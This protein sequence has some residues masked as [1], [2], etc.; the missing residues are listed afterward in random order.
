MIALAVCC[1][2]LSRSLALVSILIL[3]HESKPEPHT[4]SLHCT[5]D[6]NKANK[7]MTMDSKR[8]ATKLAGGGRTLTD[9]RCAFIEE[10]IM[11]QSWK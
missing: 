11:L 5:I 8:R 6:R 4:A 10:S 9:R 1:L 7:E 2:S 3:R